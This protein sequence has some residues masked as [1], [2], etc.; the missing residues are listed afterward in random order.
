[1]VLPRRLSVAVVA[2][3]LLV[4]QLA[5]A[6]PQSQSK[7]R[8]KSPAAKTPRQ[9]QTPQADNPAAQNARGLNL[10]QIRS[11]VSLD[12][13]GKLWA[14]VIGVSSYKNLP[15]DA[16]LKFPHRDAEEFAAF[17]R[18]PQ[19]GGFP[20]SQIKVLL[21]QEAT[22]A[23]VRTALGTWLAR[24]AEPEDSVYVYFAGHGVVEGDRD[25]YL[26]AYDSDPQNLYATALSVEELNKVISERLRTR[27]VVLITDACH[28]GR[29]GFAA[30]GVEERI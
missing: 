28:A 24:S 27:L 11:G 9:N 7:P 2:I 5:M 20:S 16:Q 4:C 26:L 30:R 14:V 23:A 15:A 12:G 22:L 19:G 6:L 8:R 10:Q 3:G 1:M 13:R 17:L 21:N 29:L 18:S 25:G